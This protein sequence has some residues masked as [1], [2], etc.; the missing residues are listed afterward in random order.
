VFDKWFSRMYEREI[1]RREQLNGRGGENIPVG[2]NPLIVIRG[3]MFS[4]VQ[5]PFAG[6]QVWS[7]LRTPNRTQQDA[8]GAVSLLDIGNEW[9]KTK[10][11]TEDLLR[12]RN[13]L[14][15]MAR[16][17]LNR[18]KFE[19]IEKML[20]GIDFVAADKRRELEEIKNIDM[21]SCTAEEKKD[22]EIRIKKLELYLAFFLPEDTLDFLGRWGYGIDISEVKKLSYDQLL[23]AAQRAERNHNAP[24]DNLSGRF[25]DRD[26]P[27]IDDSAWYCL[28]MERQAQHAERSSGK[29][30]W[31]FAGKGR[32]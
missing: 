32:R 13:S 3:A 14:E 17:V 23:L 2:Y 8:C 20:L 15:A 10:P 6:V 12:T 25:T 5:V 1:S 4:W 28:A 9:S 27:D 16:E 19:E 24:H 30:S 7:E 26:A 31:L 22:I 29:Y 18:P 11:T 21:S